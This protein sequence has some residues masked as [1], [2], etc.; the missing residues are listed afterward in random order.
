MIE[1]EDCCEKCRFF[2]EET[3]QCRRFP[4]TI[5]QRDYGESGGFFEFNFPFVGKEQLCGEF[6]PQEEGW[7]IP[8]GWVPI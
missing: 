8:E 6:K 7:V 5:V 4:P 1:N 3:G 2:K